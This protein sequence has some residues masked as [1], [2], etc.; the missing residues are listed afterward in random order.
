VR[1]AVYS[2]PGVGFGHG[3]E[4]AVAS[5]ARNA[6]EEALEQTSARRDAA[7]AQRSAE[8]Q[9]REEHFTATGW[10]HRTASGALLSGES[11]LGSERLW[12]AGRACPFLWGGT[13]AGGDFARRFLGRGGARLADSRLGLGG[14]LRAR[15]LARGLTPRR[16]SLRAVAREARDHISTRACVLRGALWSVWVAH[17][18]AII[19]YRGQK[20]V[21]RKNSACRRNLSRCIGVLKQSRGG[22]G[23]QTGPLIR[24]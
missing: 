14:S 4:A 9:H 19:A 22:Q 5:G 23:P 2:S 24:C 8:M 17:A 12:R 3:R 21:Q 7:L 15:A 1:E 18:I 6:R 13:G 16:Q 20:R 11:L 10:L